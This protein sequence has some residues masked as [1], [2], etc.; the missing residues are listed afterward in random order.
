M[1][2]PA[3]FGLAPRV[4]LRDPL[5]E[6]LGA[7]DGPIEYGYVD[8]VRLAGHSC[9][10]VAGA[11]LMARA[12]LL[13]LYPNSPGERGGVAVTM[14]FP[15][16]EGTTGVMAQ[17]FTLLTGAAGANGFQGLGD[18][19]ARRGLLDYGID[20]R[21][22]ARFRRL[23]NGVT[24]GVSLDLSRVPPVAGLRTLL[25]RAQA[26]DATDAERAAFGA[27]WQDRVRRLLLEY[28]DDPDVIR[29]ERAS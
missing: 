3:F 17:V 4:M 25:G 14:R 6:F 15:E 23:D 28:A 19:F 20:Q 24:V 13:G 10:T 5:A 29:L 21:T 11:Y 9:P 27:A 22:L 18:R 1:G 7:A 8:A 16:S 2:F 12:A 26:A